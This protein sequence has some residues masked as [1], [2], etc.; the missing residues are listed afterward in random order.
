MPAQPSSTNREA[1]IQAEVDRAIAE[2]AGLVPDHMLAKMREMAD[3]Y[4]RT[5]PIA[6]RVISVLL[7]E[8]TREVSG[9]QLVHG[10]E[11]PAPAKK[12]AGG[13]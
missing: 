12:G 3:E 5:D 8:Q 7:D 2:W 13:Q 9:G 11:E 1:I 10:A 6:V 4:F